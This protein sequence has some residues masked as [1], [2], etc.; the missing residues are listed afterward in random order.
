[1]SEIQPIN[2]AYIDSIIKAADTYNPNLSKTQGTQ[3]RELIKLMRDRFEQ[4][5][6]D[7][8]MQ[9]SELVETYSYMIAKGVP[10]TL[11]TYRVAVDEKRNSTNSIYEW[12]P[13]G[14][15][16]FIKSILDDQLPN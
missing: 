5:L 6:S 9:Q 8:P 10:V 3:L 12:W 14:K 2:D 1:M 15:I 11:K 16:Y 13:N 4:Q 7:G